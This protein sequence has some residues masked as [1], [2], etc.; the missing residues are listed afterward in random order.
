MAAR[1]NKSHDAAVRRPADVL[2]TE[3]ELNRLRHQVITMRQTILTSLN[4]LE[5]QINVLLPQPV[6]TPVKYDLETIREWAYN[7][8]KRK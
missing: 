3:L 8:G 6:R 5:D 7:G 2:A 1:A 4:S